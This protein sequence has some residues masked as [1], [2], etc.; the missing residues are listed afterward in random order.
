MIY[1]ALGDSITYG[2]D[3]SDEQKKFVS[4]VHAALS[5]KKRVSLFTVAKPGWTS[6][7]LLRSVIK[8]PKCVWDESGIVT[9]LVGGNDLLRV[10][11]WLLNGMTTKSVPIAENLTENL[12]EIVHIVKRPYNKIFI[13]T[14]YN[15]F[16]NSLVAE[17]CTGIINKSIRLVAL[18]ENLI[19][20]DIFK[21]FK[22]R[23]HRLI[24]GYKTG[25]MRD[26]KI[27]RNPIHP[28]NF[29]HLRISQ[30]FL[31][32]YRKAILSKLKEQ[33]KN[34]SGTKRAAYSSGRVQST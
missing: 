34:Q 23:E 28:N 1:A 11:P 8:V 5:K 30:A 26:F 24:E 16:P 18:R 9:I 29:G 21:T 22:K 33:R 12:R 2:Y 27:R 17:E 3:A 25:Q 13:G 32:A 20:V 14:V 7:Q 15:P 19:L 6:K 4:L 10:S 31:F